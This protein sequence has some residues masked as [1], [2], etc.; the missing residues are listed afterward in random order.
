M[1]ILEKIAYLKGLAD[2]MELASAGTKESKLLL[3]ILD[4]LEDMALDL[5]D[6]QDA[7]I[8]LEEG[9]D[10][11][12]DDLSDVESYI[13]ESE[14]D[15]DDDDDC[16]CCG[17]DDCDCDCDDEEDECYETVCP[18]C[19]PPDFPTTTAHTSCYPA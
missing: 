12:S 6:L 17:D 11:V 8:E 9:L 19:P 3:Q 15:D 4:V 5:E 13:Y 10:A 14:E 16:C 7:Q 1:E 2:G 18:V